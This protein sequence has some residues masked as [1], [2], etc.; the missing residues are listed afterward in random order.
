MFLRRAR[1]ARLRVRRRSPCRGCGSASGCGSLAAGRARRGRACSA[2][3]RTP[4]ARPRP[5][6]ARVVA[7]RTSPRSGAASAIADQRQR[8]E[9]ASVLHQAA[10]RGAIQV[11]TLDQRVVQAD[12]RDVPDQPCAATVS[13]DQPE[14]PEQQPR[15]NQLSIPP[16]IARQSPPP[17]RSLVMHRRGGS[18]ILRVSHRATLLRWYGAASVVARSA[19]LYA[20]LRNRL[21][22][23]WWGR[24][25]T[26]SSCWC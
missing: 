9:T 20:R 7:A 23:A 10:L 26:T 2:R 16:G 4:P 22:G 5:A 25:L 18:V 19:L 17:P 15:E 1:R 11:W 12:R 6:T 14:L 13:A 21:E 8:P 24:T 3:G